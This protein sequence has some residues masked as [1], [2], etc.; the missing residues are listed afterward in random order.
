[1]SVI[2]YVWKAV[3]KVP[4]ACSTVLPGQLPV[5]C[6]RPVRALKSV[7]FPTLGLPAR[8]MGI[9]WDAGTLGQD[10]F[11]LSRFR[12]AMT[13]PRIRKAWG[14]P[15]GTV[16]DAGDVCLRGASPRSRKRRLQGAG[17]ENFFYAGG[18]ARLQ[19]V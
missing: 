12:M 15:E 8:A 17:A 2:R 1:M 4:E 6:L 14:S 16:S 18:L 10:V 19:L 11:R 7:L 9:S 5:C 3:R 13:A